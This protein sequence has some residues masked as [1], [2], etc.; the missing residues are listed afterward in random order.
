MHVQFATLSQ[1]RA[2]DVGDQQRQCARV[3]RERGTEGYRRSEPSAERVGT[4]DWDWDWDRKLLGRRARA[5][6]HER[7]RTGAAALLE[8]L[9]KDVDELLVGLRVEDLVVARVALRPIQECDQLLGAQRVLVLRAASIARGALMSPV[10]IPIKQFDYARLVLYP[11]ISKSAGAPK[12]TT[13]TDTSAA[14]ARE[15][16]R[17]ESTQV[18]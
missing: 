16:S 1:Q 2:F 9:E 14:S 8:L 13:R 6:I 18:N 5:Q 7:E 10:F 11:A 15:S 4:G 17:V 3:Q 12:P